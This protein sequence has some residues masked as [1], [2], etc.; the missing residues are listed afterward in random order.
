MGRMG[1][2]HYSIINSNPNIEIESVADPSPL[3]LTMLSKYLPAKIFKD[4][5]ELLEQTKP[6]VI[7]VCT[8]PN[9]HFPIVKKAAEKGIHAFVEKPFTTKASEASELA[10]LYTTLVG[11]VGYV[12]RFNDIFDKTKE[13]LENNIIGKI[14]RFKTEMFSCTI[15]QA[16]ESSGWRA[17]RESGGGAA[18]EIA[19]HAIDVINFLIGKP[20]KVCGSSLNYLY[21]KNVEDAL[22]TTFLYKNGMSGTLY[23]NWCDTSYRK[24]ALKFEMFGE[25]GRLMADQHALKIFLI[26]PDKQYNLHQGW[27]NIYIPDISKSA[28][29]YVRGNDFSWQL[30]HFVECINNRA[31]KNRCSFSDGANV[32]EIIEN[33]FNDYEQNGRL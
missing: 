23:V 20:D 24:P 1:I 32:L 4:Y 26:E 5:N 30:F 13:L 7:L 14:I 8:P 2:T 11:Q 16:N 6:D 15:T 12:N 10:R 3:I 18:F 22:S 28:P 29:F 33:I 31:I 17:A 9:L 27:N 25:G 19:S 21:S